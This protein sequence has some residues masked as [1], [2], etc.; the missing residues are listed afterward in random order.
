MKRHYKLRNKAFTVKLNINGSI[1]KSL[2]I[3]K[4]KREAQSKYPKC[5]NPEAIRLKPQQLKFNFE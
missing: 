4:T 2:V 1:I 3:A 5:Y